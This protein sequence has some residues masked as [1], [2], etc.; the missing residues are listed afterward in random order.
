[1]AEKQGHEAD[2]SAN[3]VS[4]GSKDT[5]S[6]QNNDKWCD[7]MDA[8]LQL[9]NKFLVTRGNTEPGSRA[10][11]VF[12]GLSVEGSG[13]GVCNNYYWLSHCIR[14]IESVPIG[15]SRCN[16]PKRCTVDPRPFQAH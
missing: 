12:E 1:M 2:S 10:D 9:V 11:V 4:D 7:A 14:H 13:K 15:S 5:L 16:S 3:A 6:L 8:V